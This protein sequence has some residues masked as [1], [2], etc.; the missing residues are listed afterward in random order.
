MALSR[1]EISQIAKGAF[2]ELLKDVS[3]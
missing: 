2:D 1:E 3:W